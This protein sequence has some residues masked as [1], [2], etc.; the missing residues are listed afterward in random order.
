MTASAIQLPLLPP[1]WGIRSAQTATLGGIKLEPRFPLSQER[2]SRPN[3]FTHIV[4][5]DG[6]LLHAMT[7]SSGCRSEVHLPVG[8]TQHAV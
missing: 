1:M 5:S 8:S 4:P 3:P 6:M 2:S 7:R